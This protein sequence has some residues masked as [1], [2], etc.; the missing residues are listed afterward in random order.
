[1][2]IEGGRKTLQSFI[3]ENLWDEARVFCSGTILHDGTKA[4]EIHRGNP[5][6]YMIANDELLIFR[7]DD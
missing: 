1:V 3:D 4:P 6:K 7:N 2:I 5:R